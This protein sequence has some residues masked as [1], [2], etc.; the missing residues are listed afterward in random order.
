MNIDQERLQFRF[1]GY[2][3]QG[4]ITAGYIL[5]EAVC[6]H[7][8]RDAVMTRAYGPEVQ[9]GWARSD[10]VVHQDQV[11][12]PYITEADC[13]VALSQGEY[14]RDRASLTEDGLLIVDENLVE[15][16]DKAPSEHYSLPLVKTAE[17]E[18]GNRVVANIVTLGA[19]IGITE[20]IHPEAMEKAVED[21]VPEGTEEL[22]LEAL[23]AGR[24][25]A[26]E[27]ATVS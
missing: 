27:T 13:L 12:F 6:L 21:V 14:E 15:L 22:N 25:L 5:G 17:D 7:T 8:D 2:G 26:E 9:G 23:S 24:N 10:V 19:L 1:S 4:V 20:V 3:G 18:L 16:D 11:E